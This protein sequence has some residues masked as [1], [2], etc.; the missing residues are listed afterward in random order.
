MTGHLPGNSGYGDAELDGVV[1]TAMS[2]ILAKLEAAFDLAAGL[3]DIYARRA[4]STT[5]SSRLAA[6]C[7]QIDLLND[8]LANVVRSGQRDPI[9]GSSY[10]DLARDNL[11]Q[12][13]AGVASRTMTMH[14][15]RQLTRDIHDQLRQADR[16]LR[17]LHGTTL[18]QLAGGHPRSGGTLTEQARAVR[19]MVARL[20]EPGGHDLAF[21]PAR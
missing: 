3:A 1:S 5:G 11:V 10:L 13:R 4:A 12:L 15:A 17:S 19:E 16:I 20:Y 18:D 14:E 7:D 21:A 9:G 8:W 6:A 2:G